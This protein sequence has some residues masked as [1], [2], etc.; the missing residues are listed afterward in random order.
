MD[1]VLFGYLGQHNWTH[2]VHTPGRRLRKEYID[3]I[4]KDAIDKHLFGSEV[5][6][7][8]PGRYESFLG[9][10]EKLSEYENINAVKMGNKGSISWSNN[11]ARYIEAFLNDK[12]VDAIGAGDSFNAGFIYKFIQGENITECQKFGNLMGAVNTTAAGGT[13][14]FTNYEEILKV[15]REKFNYTD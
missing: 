14:A 11:K 15:A 13:G 6:N 1:F 9:P 7:K 12:V 4:I 8:Q 3:V 10:T 5:E 2:Y